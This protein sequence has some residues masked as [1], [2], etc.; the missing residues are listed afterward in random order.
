MP[1]KGAPRV[2]NDPSD[3]LVVG[4]GVIGL[5]IAWRAAQQ[6]LSVTV[7][8]ASTAG[9]ASHAAAG[10]LAPITE[11]KPTEEAL[12]RLGLEGQRLWPAFA[13]ELT[14]A[15]GMDIGYRTQGTL[16]VALDN[17]DKADLDRL[18]KILAGFGVDADTLTSRETRQL[19]PMLSPD[20]RS[21]LLVPSDHSVDPRLL[22]DALRVAAR[23][24][25]ATIEQRELTSLAATSSST[26]V[27][28]AGCWSRALARTVGIHLDVR[29]VKGQ[30]LR[31]HD[32]SGRF[33]TRTVRGVVNGS[34]IYLVPRGDGEVVLGATQEE[35]GH[36]T[37][38]TAGGVW[39]LL[40][41]ARALLPGVTE[42]TFVEAISGLR[43]M[44]RDNTP[45]IKRA[46]DDLIVATGHGRNGVLLAPLTAERVV[47]ELIGVRP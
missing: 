35:L 5:S 4:G 9:R 33:L 30:V 16:A 32:A 38:V 12:L 21:G 15:G 2:S 42:L 27:L 1:A 14:A 45:I 8:D 40:R 39:E 6:G 11:T 17:D 25:G 20:V 28:A 10:M 3:V 46:A 37:T 47:A 13:A 41:D 31:L 18:A 26:T 43:P 23:K 36:D 29:P 34:S 19:E 24:A 44:T 7:V 22:T